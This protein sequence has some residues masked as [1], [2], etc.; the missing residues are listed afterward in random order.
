[1][2][3]STLN[4]QYLQRSKK[5]KEEAQEFIEKKKFEDK[6]QPYGKF[7][8]VGSFKTDLMVWRDLD[9]QIILDDYE[10]RLDIFAKISS[11]LLEDRELKSIKLINFFQ[12]KKKSMPVGLYMGMSFT[13]QSQEDWK[14]DL[15]TLDEKDQK[16]SSEFTQKLEEKLTPKHRELILSWKYR[17]MKDQKRV[18]QLGSYF[19][20]QAIVFEE[21][22]DEKSII[23]YLRSKGLEV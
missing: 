16:Q 8:I 17:L 20:Y 13:T 21:L 10:K 18:P 6:L 4:K 9:L 1:M 2:I 12:G 19:L 14:V 15:W 11:Q 3:D 7:L 22:S 23:S 5:L